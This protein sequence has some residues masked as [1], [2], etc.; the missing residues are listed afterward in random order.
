MR[1]PFLSDEIGKLVLRLT[2]GV[3]MLFHGVAKVLNPAALDGIGK[4]LAG[5]GLPSFVAYGAYVGEVL[6]PLMLI[7]GIFARIGGLLVAANM[8]FA[9]VLAHRADIF[10]LSKHG[11]WALELQGFYLFCGVAIALLGSGR[12]MAVRPD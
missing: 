11:G 3:L 1:N 10:T 8:V 12:L 4:Q 9:I 7:F 5:I 2:V 6:A